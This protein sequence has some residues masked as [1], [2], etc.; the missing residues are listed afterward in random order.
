MEKNKDLIEQIKEIGFAVGDEKIVPDKDRSYLVKFIDNLYD[1]NPNLHDTSSNAPVIMGLLGVDPE[2]DRIFNSILIHPKI[3]NTL[4]AIH[5]EDYK[6]WEI[7]ARYSLPG[8]VGLGIHQDAYAQ[9][10]LALHLGDF[11][12]ENG[13]TSLIPRSHYLSRWS[14][15]ISWARP[16]IGNFFA[17]NL[18]FGESDFAFF[19]NKTWHGRTKNISKRRKKIILIGTFPPGGKFECKIPSSV[20]EKISPKFSE[21][22]NRLDLKNGVKSLGN[23]FYLIISKSP[24]DVITPF[25]L[26]IENNKKYFLNSLPF[27]LKAILLEIVFKPL[28]FLYR[29]MKKI[30]KKVRH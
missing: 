17:K 8:D 30:K 1:T 11:E 24:G 18:R 12:D 3:Q 16:E 29:I 7:S 21:L 20:V 19:L 2:L 28:Q 4:F 9:M 25:S 22:R 5:G 10:N 15:K 27:L 6:I 13:V 23:G 14:D 26:D